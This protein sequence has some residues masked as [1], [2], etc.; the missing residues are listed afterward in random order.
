MKINAGCGRHTWNGY[1]CIDAVQHPKATRPIDLEFTFSFDNGDLVELVPLPDGCASEV[2]NG[3]FIEH[4]HEW[5][6]PAVVAEFYRLL[7]PGG[8]LVME[9]PDLELACRN[10]LKGK[11]DQY[12]MWPLY[13]DGT[14]RDPLM[15]HKFG[16]TKKTITALLAD[17]GFRNIR[18]LPPQTHG[19]R[20]NRD[21]RVEAIK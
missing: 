13:G 20:A 14:L 12:S 2:F 9:L 10:L 3:H 15:C 1:Y 18:N 17:C 7:E 16:Y 5:E 4:V 6:A 8:L 11:P 19:K 21:M